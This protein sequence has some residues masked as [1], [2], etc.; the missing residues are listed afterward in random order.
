MTDY[1]SL[2]PRL[3]ELWP[4]FNAV[5]SWDWG[6]TQPLAELILTEPIPP[7]FQAAVSAIVSGTRKR[8]RNWHKSKIPA[9][10]RMKIAG[11][12]SYIIDLCRVIRRGAAEGLEVMADRLAMEPIDIV[13]QTEGE[14]RKVQADA[15]EQLGVSVETIVNLLREMRKKIKRWPV[16]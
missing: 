8:S 12:I 2:P 15:A 13:R 6:D 11:S 7:E 9:A 1:L 3:N 5:S 14:A 10:E 4:W 16:V